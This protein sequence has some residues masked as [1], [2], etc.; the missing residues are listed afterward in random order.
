MNFRLKPHARVTTTRLLPKKKKTRRGNRLK[1][2]YHPAPLLHSC[3]WLPRHTAL[4]FWDDFFAFWE[5]FASF[6]AAFLSAFFA[7]FWSAFLALS[8]FLSLLLF[9][10]DEDPT[11]LA[12]AP[13]DPTHRG[14]G[15]PP[16]TRRWQPQPVEE[17]QAPHTP[18]P[19]KNK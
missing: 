2:W 16:V 5:D 15:R 19:K 18:P 14:A 13:A 10:G 6:L 17:C 8:F 4:D 1:M 12:T 7:P 9:L 11:F 3:V